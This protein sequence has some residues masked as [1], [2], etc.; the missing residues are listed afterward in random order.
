[1]RAVDCVEQILFFFVYH[2]DEL[3]DDLGIGLR[4]KADAVIFNQLL[5]QLL[6]IFD[7]AVVNDGDLARLIG[8]RV[9]VDIRRR[10]VRS[11]ARMADADMAFQLVGP[12]QPVQ[13]FNAAHVLSD[14]QLSVPD[15][16]DAGRIIASVFKA[17]ESVDDHV[18]GVVISYVSYYS[19]HIKLL[20]KYFFPLS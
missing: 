17:L 10:T 9:S 7:D 15:D 18:L 5:P 6:I 1:Q 19:T 12:D 8:M 3:G 14:L 20:F 4:A 11:P 2:T 13:I 16:G